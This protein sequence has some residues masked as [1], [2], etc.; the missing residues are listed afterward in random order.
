MPTNG[1]PPPIETRLSALN[2]AIEAEAAGT[3]RSQ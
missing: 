1:E 2:S 3:K